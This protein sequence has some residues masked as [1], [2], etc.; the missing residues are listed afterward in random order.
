[1]KHS[2]TIP[3]GQKHHC[4][5]PDNIDLSIDPGEKLDPFFKLRYLIRLPRLVPD[6]PK[7]SYIIIVL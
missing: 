5:R 4:P 2:E 6:N 3:L 1:M 7:I